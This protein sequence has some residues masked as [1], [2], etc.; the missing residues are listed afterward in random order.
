[1]YK[2]KRIE[3]KSYDVFS[4][5]PSTCN[6]N[7]NANWYNKKSEMNRKSAS[8]VEATRHGIILRSIQWFFY[9]FW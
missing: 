2:D 3:W 8:L 6:S 5:V 1:M 9:K 4:N 7:E